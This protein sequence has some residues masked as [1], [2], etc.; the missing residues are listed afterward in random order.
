M[1]RGSPSRRAVISATAGAFPSVTRNPGRTASARSVKSR[2]AS[3]RPRV[4]TSG[5]RSGSGGSSGGTS[6]SCSPR[7]DSTILEVTSTLSFGAEVRRSSITGACSA[8]C[9][10]LST[11]SRSSRSRRWSLTPSRMGRPGTSGTPSARAMAAGT[12]AG[13][14]TVERSTKKAPSR[15]SVSASPATWR[16]SRDFPVPPAPVRVRT[17]VPPSSRLTS[18]IS[19]S[20]PTNDV[21]C[22]GRLF[23]LASM[24][25]GG[26]KS[27]GRSS[28]TRSWRRS[29]C[30]MSR[31]RCSPRSRSVTPSGSERSTSARVAS[32]RMTCPPWA[33]SEI[34]AARFTS[35]PT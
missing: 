26:G 20:L 3:N 10:K 30:S 9:S 22:A 15:N 14:V 7:T 19:F 29:G 34:R 33:A 17:L 4:R 13:S 23:G 2:T 28:I 16:A 12:S 11:T 31:S 27:A 5:S 6:H 21:S 25:R 1:A 32:E 8:T 24:V 35:M 18:A